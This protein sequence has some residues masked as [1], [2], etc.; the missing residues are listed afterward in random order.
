V[1]RSILKWTRIV[2]KEEK[3]RVTEKY[4]PLRRLVYLKVSN[5][6][7]LIG[8]ELMLFEKKMEIK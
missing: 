1:Q 6:A 4:R 3:T 5:T 2:P 8:L 7:K